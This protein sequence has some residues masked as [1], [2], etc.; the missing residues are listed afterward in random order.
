MSWYSLFSPDIA[1]WVALLIFAATLTLILYRKINI[2]NIS[3]GAAGLLIL[4]GV[5]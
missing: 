4:I 3:L 1:M 2:A 5:N